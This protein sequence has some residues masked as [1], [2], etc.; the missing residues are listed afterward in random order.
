M[1]IL[2]GFEKEQRGKVCKLKKSLY[3][4]K[5][6]LRAWFKSFSSAVKIFGY[7]Q[8]QVDHT[9]FTKHSHDGK[10]YILIVYVNDIIIKGDDVQEI[11]NLKA[12][13]GVRELGNIRY[14]LGMEVARSK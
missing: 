7:H 13:F 4:L 3:G 5:Q 12:E 10:I 1:K 14:F 8:G 6:S 11:R 9:L 2:P